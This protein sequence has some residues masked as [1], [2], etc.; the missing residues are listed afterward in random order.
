[1][2]S[3]ACF[4]SGWMG[5]WAWVSTPRQGKKGALTLETADWI[6]KELQ[7]R[8]VFLWR[9]GDDLRFR[10]PKGALTPELRGHVRAQR[11]YLLG[12]LTGQTTVGDALPLSDLQRA[13]WLGE[14]DPEHSVPAFWYERYDTEAFDPERF[15][16]AWRRLVRRHDVLRMCVNAEGRQVVHPP[17]EDFELEVED[18]GGLDT[19]VQRRRI[20]ETRNEFLVPQGTLGTPPLIR[21]RAQKLDSRWTVHVSGR[22][23]VMDGYS[24]DRF[25]QELALVVEDPERTLEP[26]DG[27]YSQFVLDGAH[28]LRNAEYQADLDWWVE[29]DLPDAPELP[30]RRS[31][32][33][34]SR[35]QKRF[36]RRQA[37]LNEE[38]SRALAERS[39][40]R[41]L[42]LNS[43]L[44]AAYARTLAVWSSQPQFC[45]N[46]LQTARRRS[47]VEVREPLSNA[48]LTLLLHVDAR[49]GS[50]LEFAKG[51]QHV[52]LQSLSHSF[53]GGSRVLREQAARTGKPIRANPF[54][55]ASTV[56]MADHDKCYGLERLGWRA[57]DSYMQTPHVLLDYQVFEKP[58]GLLI[59]WDSVVGAFEAGVV[60]NMFD[61][62]G[63]LLNALSASDSSW[64]QPLGGVLPRPQAT[65]REKVNSNAVELAPRRLHDFVQ[66]WQADDTDPDAIV[67]G[68][69][70]RSRRE[71]IAA[72]ADIRARL[73]SLGVKRGAVV[74]IATRDAL[75]QVISA[76]GV[77]LAGAAYVP[78]SGVPP[79]RA[80]AI[81]SDLEARVAIAD[82]E[83]EG[84]LPP[85]V[86]VIRIEEIAG[87]ALEFSP[88]SPDDLAYVIFT[89]GSTGKPKG[90]A[91]THDAACNTIAAVNQRWGVSKDDVFFGV[92]QFTFDLSVYDIFGAF[93]KGS[94]LVLPTSE[95]VRDP[96][97]WYR[98]LQSEKVTIWNSVPALAEMLIDYL[99]THGL[100]IPSLRLVLL[101]GDWVPLELPDRIRRCCPDA[102]VVTLGGATEAGIW[103]NFFEV[104]R[105]ADGWLSIPYGFAL[106]NQSLHVLNANLEDRPDYCE[107]DLYIGG[108]SLAQEYW[109]DAERTRRSFITHPRTG[110]RLY[111]TGD[112]ARFWADGTVE[113]LGRAD[114]QVKIRG[115]RIELGEIESALLSY[116][117]IESA[118]AVVVRR[119]AGVTLECGVVTPLNLDESNDGLMRH[120]TERLPHYMIP[121]H[122][123]AIES[124]P[125]SAHGKV[126]RTWVAQRLEAKERQRKGREGAPTSELERSIQEIWQGVLGSDDV[127]VDESFFGLGGDSL[128]VMR[129]LNL[130]E[131]KHGVRVPFSAVLSGLSIR[132]TAA[133]IANGKGEDSNLVHVLSGASLDRKLVC[134]HPI[135]GTT[136]GYREMAGHLEE[137]F[138]VLGVN[139][140]GCLGGTPDRS[141][142]AMAARY[143]AVLRRQVDSRCVIVG[144]SFGAVV[145]F[146]VARQLR[147]TN[148][149][150]FVVGIDPWVRQSPNEVRS[151]QSW[152][153]AYDGALGAER[154]QGHDHESLSYLV[155][156]DYLQTFIANGQALL[157]HAPTQALAK[158]ELFAA[159]LAVQEP[160][161]GL[162]P[163][164]QSS[165]WDVEEPTALEE[166]H[167]SIVRGRSASYLADRIVQVAGRHYAS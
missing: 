163:I 39:R 88:C 158:H 89:S 94:R 152:L 150:C 43:V 154:G 80:Q 14:N 9:D 93:S 71:L 25:C 52:L 11:E 62:H 115:H 76:L 129:M 167:Y 140:L 41:G 101:S 78:L 132:S 166:D 100:N 29:R 20:E 159:S 126:D 37:G 148:V 46:V 97:A 92:S 2:H 74:P 99:E 117:G 38:Q 31:H 65:A 134:I 142:E 108:R 157:A 13:Y 118:V 32:G 87:R 119:D 124:V 22:L 103:S 70:R 153:D 64:E 137:H 144:W 58:G 33:R 145:A 56:G 26:I 51:L 45:L 104:D 73:L 57:V 81:L 165:E 114:S 98:T 77:Q 113:F 27:T 54:V 48:A 160:F 7:A 28:A 49:R 143:T 155:R 106:P 151:E 66:E 156:E 18:L 146:E 30:L 139:A 125:L 127:P 162:I 122:I 79:R 36:E 128:A 95:E 141:V 109:G 8:Q 61:E 105:V 161:P 12:R 90:V 35:G 40:L 24:W 135:G 16:S 82:A 67:V 21:L 147:G 53:V 136:L 1:M 83:A 102:K 5:A 50:F 15:Q 91:M 17:S 10:G 84:D 19:L 3:S 23:I 4:N 112:R 131:R 44:C 34:E 75:G 60:Q 96:A 164:A 68:A 59:N 107:G 6:L 63:R 123:Q 55:F 121:A 110:A 149:D 133:Q 72:A 47:E 111:R 130:V 69:Q 116:D 120:L 42:T 138:R 85:G 86:R